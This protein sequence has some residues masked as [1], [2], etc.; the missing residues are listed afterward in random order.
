[1]KYVLD[2]RGHCQDP[3]IVLRLSKLLILFLPLLFL[4][5]CNTM[6]RKKTGLK[7]TG[8]PA[9]TQLPVTLIAGLHDSLKPKTI[10][11]DL[12]PLSHSVAV[13]KNGGMTKML[14][15]LQNE[16]GE[17]IL[18]SE[19]NP[20]ILGD[21]GKSNF[22][23]F[24]T[25]NGLALDAISCSVMDRSGNLWFGTYGGGVSRYDGK[26]FT[27][28][29]TAQGLANNMVWSILEDKSGNLWFGTYGGGV[30]CY[31][32]RSFTS[33]T[34]VDGLA[35][36]MVW[37]I[38]EDKAGTLWFGTDGGGV[39]RYDGRSFTSFTT[40]KGLANNHV[41]SI[42]Q[43][44]T[45]NL[46]FGTLGGG[47]SRFD[48]ISFT[49]FTTK[50]GL[51][52]NFIYSMLEDKSGCLWFSTDGGGVSR[53]DG[54]SFSSFTT[55]CGLANNIVWSSLEDKAGNL[56]FGTYGGGVSR[57]DGKSFTTFTTGQGLA[58]NIIYS[59]LEDKTGSLWFGTDGGGISRYNGKS[60][61]SFTTSQG[62]ANNMVWSILEDK[63][64]ILWFGT[65]GGGVSRYDGKSFT[66]YTTA[67]GLSNNIVFSIL[68]DKTGSL[69]FGTNGGGASCYNGKSFTTFTTV[70][71][72]ANNNVR[73]IAEDNTGGLWFGTN[74]GG[75]SRYD[76][77]SF[78]TYTTA[79][80]LASNSVY[81]I[82]KDKTGN[83]WFGTYG[84]GV[85]RYDGE[86]FTTLTTSQGLANNM[87]YCILEDKTGNLWFGTDEG[88]SVMPAR[89]VRK[90]EEKRDN[91]KNEYIVSSS[92]LKSFKIADGLPDDFVTNVIQLPNGKMAVGTNLG[93]TIFTPS[94]DFSKLK[95]IEI[96][97]SGTGYPVK[98]VNVGQNCMSLDKNGIVW[99]GTGSETSGLIRFDYRVVKENN[100]EPKLVIQRIKVDEEP[101]CWYNIQSKGVS[102]DKRD[103]AT[104]LL[105]E[106]FAYG[107]RHT[108][109]QNQSILKRFGNIQFDGITNFYP[110]PENLVLP[111][112]HN[113]ISFDF[114][115]IETS[116]P[117]L[118]N[119]QYKLEGYDKGWSPVTNRSNASFGNIKEGIYSFQLKAQ[120]VNGVWCKPI[121]YTFEV[122]PPVYRTWWAYLIYA[123][124]FLA[125]LH[126]FSK[127]R[128]R[129]LRAE[130]E[131]LERIVV[132]R[133]VVVEKQNEE[134][135]QKKI[136]IE[137]Q[138]AVVEKE[139]QRSD[140]LLLNIL[141]EEVA[142]EL[143]AKGSAE[144]KQ[145]EEVT[146]LFTDFKDF[147]R[148]SE[149]MA[150]RELVEELHTC[151]MAI[152]NIIEK[153]G[154]E[155]IKT[156]G[157]SYMC[158]GGLPVAN[159]THAADVVGA[160]LEIQKYIKKHIEEKTASGK[161]PFH[162]RIGI[163]T[164]P[165]VAGIV[166]IR[167]FAYDIW[168]DTVNTASRMETNGEEEK[169]NISGST[170]E[171]VKD[172]FTC[173]H[174]GKI[175]VKGKGELDMY[176]V[177]GRM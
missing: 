170:Y 35:S 47:V 60:F 53:Y 32:G 141:P 8:Q 83:L 77:K 61:T 104:A 166:G 79:Q 69:W 136:L 110:L 131:K 153:F 36:N 9:L 30:S 85:S 89:D 22:T 159:K 127:W 174:R 149:K 48:G 90:L 97:N 172:I 38:L 121:A 125:A 167:K 68:E 84:G 111:Y 98:D 1:V 94:N 11:L 66:S 129:N 122:L 113:H 107:N 177:E 138:K 52:N 95:D 31:D 163:H 120:G 10:A 72:L 45:G 91:L 148:I 12:L 80:G 160:G 39:S 73:S 139:K 157:D 27:S 146:V 81:C 100:L 114:V 37:S 135:V 96:Y 75:A 41:R 105:Q 67:H 54:K 2:A 56:W 158:A 118:V 20:F 142:E 93:I 13:S 140:D 102:N 26:S 92:L 145:F 29:T 82:F 116:R 175:T 42:L 106:F 109:Y 4:F 123:I 3:N 59:I 112:E 34:I 55:D 57:Y 169:V 176:F 86:S 70:Q 128:E 76:G 58:N 103:S 43:D 132:E 156:I 101:V 49:S 46:W 143:K 173:I 25:D 17:A 65:N 164:G 154:I 44:K 115:A 130:K 161:E 24:T 33:F 5:S 62:L 23:N 87:V 134:L 150:P 88:L 18:N 168:G 99:A 137:K 19:G 171:L 147:T 21:F 50:Q 126:M 15:V 108:S 162:I 119:Y 51:A 6:Q 165:V 144:A 40:A 28:F 151:F 14:P 74:G 63:A 71:G 152:D 64:G 133:T 16:R 78:T 124:L 155:K 7:A 117:F